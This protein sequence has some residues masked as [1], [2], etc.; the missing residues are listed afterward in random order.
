MQCHLSTI[1]FRY[2][3][4]PCDPLKLPMHGIIEPCNSK[5]LELP[6]EIEKSIQHINIPSSSSIMLFIFQAQ[7][8]TKEANL[9]AVVD[10]VETM[11]TN[12]VMDHEDS[13]P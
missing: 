1:S 8:A 9:T 6:N 7:K 3:S 4:L 5:G 10:N 2:Y 11:D 12:L 13:H